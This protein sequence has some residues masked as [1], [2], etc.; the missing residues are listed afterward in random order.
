MR[1]TRIFSRDLDRLRLYI[2]ESYRGVRCPICSTA[3]D[4]ARLIH[5]NLTQHF[6]LD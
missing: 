4:D 3:H 5:S 1:D 6:S 2:S